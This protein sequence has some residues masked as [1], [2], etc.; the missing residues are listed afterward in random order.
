MRDRGGQAHRRVG[1]LCSADPADVSLAP[2]CLPRQS[3]EDAG[4]PGPA[5]PQ[6]LS[7]VH[8]PTH[9]LAL[10]GDWDYVNPN[11]PVPTAN[12]APSFQVTWPHYRQ[13]PPLDF[14]HLLQLTS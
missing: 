3:P 7:P 13:S 11:P 4:D 10:W 9:A 12:S 2:A 8:P 14:F 5:D 6:L 1:P